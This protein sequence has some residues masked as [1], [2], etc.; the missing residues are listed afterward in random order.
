MN[1]RPLKILQLNV[2]RSNLRMHA[3][4]N[5]L[6]DFDILLLQE[7]WFG[8]IGVSR[9]SSDPQGLDVKGTIANPAWEPFIPEAGADNSPP[10]VATFVRRGIH[11]LTV[12]PRPDII[13]SKRY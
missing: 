8:R 7:P 10:R 11:M 1:L 6:T 3:V 12:C 9:S 2:A 5:T 13:G 4:L